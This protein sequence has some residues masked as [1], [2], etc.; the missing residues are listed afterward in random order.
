MRLE[1]KGRES[2]KARGPLRIF[3]NT[4]QVAREIGNYLVSQKNVEI[5]R[6]SSVK[7]DQLTG[8][9][10]LIVGSPTRGFR[11][12]EGITNFLKRIPAEGLKGTKVAAFDTRI[13]I[14]DIKS[15]IL[16]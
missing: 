3:G 6:V 10:L 16:D 12:T 9:E 11:P 8:V 15:S 4:E 7:L 5:L 14:N 13:S 1:R 2:G